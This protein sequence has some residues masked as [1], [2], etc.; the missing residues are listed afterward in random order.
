MFEGAERKQRGLAGETS[1]G[2]EAAKEAC[3]LTHLFRRMRGLNPAA[4]K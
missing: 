2:T 4:G 1:Q 3:E